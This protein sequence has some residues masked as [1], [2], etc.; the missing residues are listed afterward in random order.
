MTSTM[1]YAVDNDMQ[2]PMDSDNSR[3]REKLRWKQG[4]KTGHHVQ[5]MKTISAI[6]RLRNS[7]GYVSADELLEAIRLEWTS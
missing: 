2:T 4:Y 3:I 1:D 5:A 7:S 6:D